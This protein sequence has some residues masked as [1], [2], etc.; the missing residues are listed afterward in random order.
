MYFFFI[1]FF[2][3]LGIFFVLKKYIKLEKSKT[4]NNIEFKLIFF[5]SNAK[6]LKKK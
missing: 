6:K 2:K 4:H 1:F 3:N 5:L